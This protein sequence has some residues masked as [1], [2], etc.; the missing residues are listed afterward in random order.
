[1][2]LVVLDSFAST[3]TDL[4]FDAFAE[5]A[6]LTVYPQTMPHEIAE[7]IGTA[8][9]LITNKC[10][11]TKEILDAC[12]N[13]KYIGITATGYNIIDLDACKERGIVVT[14]VPAYSTSAVA[15]QVFAYLLSLANRVERHHKRVLQDEWSKS[16]N[17]CFYEP[18]LFELAGKTLGLFGFGDIAKR[19]ASLAHAFD[20]QVCVHTRTVRETDRAAFPYVRFLSFEELLAQSDMLSIHCPLTPETE[21][22]FNAAALA[23]MK[24][25]AILIN[26]ARGPVV[27]E[28]AV[29]DTLTSGKLA[30]FCA[31]VLSAEPP[32]PD[33][34]LIH[35]PNTLIT[36]HTAWAPTETR[37]RLLSAVY[38][39]L[40][41]FQKGVVKNNVA[42]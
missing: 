6:D 2:K 42:K 36:P 22:K 32:A 24:H 18:G 1:M 33:H 41:S 4:S 21:H 13:L 15:Q 28:Q 26:T 11:I 34:P 25:S 37:K 31:D 40:Q 10:T 38:D 27:D 8:D 16:T 3:S 12:P 23:Q 29:A 17:F 39:N 20:M 9:L 19:V 35:A 14:N 30:H 7:R 5:L